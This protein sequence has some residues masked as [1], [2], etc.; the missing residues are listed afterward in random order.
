LYAAT[1]DS[2]R[3]AYQ[4]L[5]SGPTDLVYVP[6][7]VSHLELNWADPAYAAFLRRLAD[8]LRVTVFDK[9]GSGLSDRVELVPDL[10]SRM[11]DIHAVMDACDIEHAVLFGVS[12]GAAMSTLFAAAYP[13]RVRVLVMYAPL[14][15]APRTR[16]RHV[17]PAGAGEVGARLSV[18]NAARGL[19]E[20]ACPDPGWLGVG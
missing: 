6:A 1:A 5:G 18:G 2:I 7:W 10:E 9:R 15:R 8:S 11:E 16:T 20:G 14:A 13:H 4:V 17:R 19:R 12:W 3:I